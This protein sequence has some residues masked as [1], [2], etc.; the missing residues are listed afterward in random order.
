MKFR[1]HV[2]SAVI[3]AVITVIIMSFVIALAMYLWDPA[4]YHIGPIE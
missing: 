4:T 2:V 1:Q 3:R